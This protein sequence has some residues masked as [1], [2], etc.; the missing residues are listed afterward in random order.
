MIMVLG[1]PGEFDSLRPNEIP[2]VG[3][4]VWSGF[5]SQAIGAFFQ[6]ISPDDL[7]PKISVDLSFPDLFEGILAEIPQ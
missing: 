5:P 2:Q 3:K 4:V 1:Q 6:Y 7:S